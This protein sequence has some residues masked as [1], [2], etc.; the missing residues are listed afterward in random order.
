MLGK[1]TVAYPANNLPVFNVNQNSIAVI[2]AYPMGGRTDMRPGLEAVCS[3]Y[4]FETKC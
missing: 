3:L 1:P 2:T 4:V